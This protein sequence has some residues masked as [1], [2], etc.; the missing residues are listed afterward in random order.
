VSPEL[1]AGEGGSG[2]GCRGGWTSPDGSVFASGPGF[3]V[4][5]KGVEMR[6]RMCNPTCFA[7]AALAL[8]F[9][10]TAPVLAVDKVVLFEEFGASW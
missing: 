7:L 3:N 2:V 6:K 8:G 4:R 5:E 1:D 10:L 9:L